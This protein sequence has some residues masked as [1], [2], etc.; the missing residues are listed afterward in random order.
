VLIDTELFEPGSHLG[1]A[2]PLQWAKYDALPIR[3]HLEVF[4]AIKACRDRLRKGD[5]IFDG[6][7]SEHDSILQ[8]NKE[9]LPMVILVVIAD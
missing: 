4:H 5:L 7:L 2:A 9:I 3:G 8:G 1:G 6:L